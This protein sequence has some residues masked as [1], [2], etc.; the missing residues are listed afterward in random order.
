M[1][2]TDVVFLES[3]LVDILVIAVNRGMSDNVKQ[4]VID[5]VYT[6]TAI[7]SETFSMSSVHSNVH[8]ASL[9]AL[10]NIAGT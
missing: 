3:V 7:E 5:R 2:N 4:S 10:R 8:L 1:T 6:M 9:E